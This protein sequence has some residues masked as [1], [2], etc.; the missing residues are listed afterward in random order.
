[1]PDLA[2][3][4]VEHATATSFSFH[5]EEDLPLPL[6][7]AAGRSPEPEWR[8]PLAGRSVEYSVPENVR[9]LVLLQGERVIERVPVA[10]PVGV[11]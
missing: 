11:S 8:A 7:D 1:M 6:I 10:Q 4:V 3:V 2:R 9:T 5:T